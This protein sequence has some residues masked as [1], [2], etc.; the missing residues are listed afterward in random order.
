MLAEI[1]G[2]WVAAPDVARLM[3]EADRIVSF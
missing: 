2:E 3:G 1:G